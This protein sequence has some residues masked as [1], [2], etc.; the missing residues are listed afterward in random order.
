MAMTPLDQAWLYRF[1]G[2]KPADDGNDLMKS[3]DI[4]VKSDFESVPLS[5][6]FRLPSVGN[7]W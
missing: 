2:Q 7:W 1:G 6:I 5:R 3:H 4:K